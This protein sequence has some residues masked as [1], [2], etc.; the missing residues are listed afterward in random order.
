MIRGGAGPD[1][2]REVLVS[3]LCLLLHFRC[4]LLF[5]GIS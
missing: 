4:R 3:H 2:R 5:V 1:F